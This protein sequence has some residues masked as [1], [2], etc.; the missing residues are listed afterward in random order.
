MM[1]VNI[2]RKKAMTPPWAPDRF[3]AFI[4]EKIKQP[5]AEEILFGALTEGGIVTVDYDGEKLGFAYEKRTPPALPKSSS[6]E[7]PPQSDESETVDR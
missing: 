7:E 1:R 2:W 3:H 6:N 4:Q 5:L